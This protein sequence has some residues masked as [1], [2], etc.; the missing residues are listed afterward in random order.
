MFPLNPIK[1]ELTIN[2]EGLCAGKERLGGLCTGFIYS[3]VG[4]GLITFGAFG[5]GVAS[6]GAGS[7]VS[8]V[9]GGIFS[10]G[11]VFFLGGTAYRKC[12]PTEPVPNR[13]EQQ[14]HEVGLK[15]VVVE[16]EQKSAQKQKVEERPNLTPCAVSRLVQCLDSKQ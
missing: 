14:G 4:A 13:T 3:V 12:R 11:G 6:G 10:L 8:Y 5:G 1:R 16:Q 7:I 9:F 15:K 2:K